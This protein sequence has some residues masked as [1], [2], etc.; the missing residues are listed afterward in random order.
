MLMVNE[1]HGKQNLEWK[2]KEGENNVLS[3][4]SVDP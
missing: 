2:V 1:I 4:P 3:F